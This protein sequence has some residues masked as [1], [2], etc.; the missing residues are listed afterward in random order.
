MENTS[1][2][3]NNL[4]AFYF[5]CGTLPIFAYYLHRL[6]KS[7][8][9]VST[10]PVTMDDIEATA[11]RQ[12]AEGD[13]AA[14]KWVTDHLR[15]ANKPIKSKQRAVF[16]TDKNIMNDAVAALVAVKYKKEE[17]KKVVARLCKNKKYNNVGELLVDCFKNK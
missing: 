12:A 2:V 17:A 16:L 11:M 7:I 13:Q 3:N 15:G 5:V 4:V 9:S 10:R 6:I 14:R 1:V 8:E